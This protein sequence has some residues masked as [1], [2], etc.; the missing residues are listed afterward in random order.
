MR[1]PARDRV[2]RRPMYDTLEGRYSAGSLLGWPAVGGRRS[3]LCGRLIR[4]EATNR[5]PQPVSGPG[6][7]R[8][9]TSSARRQRRDLPLRSIVPAPVDSTRTPTPRRP[10]LAP[11]A[12]PEDRE[13]AMAPTA[14]PGSAG[15]SR[16]DAPAQPGGR[17]T[18]PA[19]HDPRA[20][21]LPRPSRRSASS[22]AILRP[23]ESPRPPRRVLRWRPRAR[24]VQPRRRTPRRGRSRPPRRPSPVRGR[25]HPRTATRAAEPAA[26]TPRRRSRRRP[27]SGRPTAPASRSRSRSPGRRS[28]ATPAASSPTTGR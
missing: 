2:R 28:P 25:R 13:P 8:A 11:A 12:P 4:T 22:S 9:R 5:W 14:S 23:V 1:R 19:S 21:D 17:R 7:G 24:P 3:R 20:T 15:A 6:S 10:P 16:L 26:T 27:P 18:S